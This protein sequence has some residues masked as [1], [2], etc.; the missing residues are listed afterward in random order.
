VAADEP[1][2]VNVAALRGVY[3]IVNEG[4]RDCT[5]VARGALD[6]GVHL[7]QYR[8]KR[9]INHVHLRV[10]R[11][12]T[13][14]AGALLI[15]NDDWQAALAYGCDGVHLGPDDAGFVDVAPV[16]AALGAR[17]IGLS[18]GTVEEARTAQHVGADYVGVGSVFA[19][20]SKADAGEPIGIAGLR[21]VAAATTLPVAA[22]GGIG[23]AQLPSVRASGVAMAAVISAVGDAPDPREAA[24]E[25]VE[26]WNRG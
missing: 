24:R 14:A 7:I 19:T 13:R 16:R 26:I 8:A 9:G 22:I 4:A 17:I 21:R 5:A 6:A 20:V 18:C 23:R 3:V 11:E 10:L 15:V 25:L 2:I 12:L 1:A